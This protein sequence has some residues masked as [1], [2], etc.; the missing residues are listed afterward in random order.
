MCMTG[1]HLVSEKYFHVV[2]R[3]H[4]LFKSEATESREERWT[5]NSETNNQNTEM[6]TA[7]MFPVVSV[8]SRPTHPGNLRCVMC[9]CLQLHTCVG[10]RPPLGVHGPVR[11]SL[12]GTDPHLSAFF[13]RQPMDGLHLSVRRPSRVACG[14]SFLPGGQI[15]VMILGW[16]PRRGDIQ[17]DQLRVHLETW[18]KS[19]A[20]WRTSGG[21]P[22]RGQR[23]SACPGYGSCC[24]GWLNC[25]ASLFRQKHPRQHSPTSP[26]GLLITVWTDFPYLQDSFNPIYIGNLFIIL[27]SGLP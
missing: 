22:G 3:V 16:P 25:K 27:Y 26:L 24:L 14:A 13:Q 21:E 10:V 20:E 5:R 4:C 23:G 6:L 19:E 11:G 15:F 12:W 7:V 18:C 8:N 2:I 17:A 9:L 1:Y